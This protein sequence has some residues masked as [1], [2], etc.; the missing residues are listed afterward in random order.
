MWSKLT[1]Y[2]PFQFAVVLSELSVITITITSSER[3]EQTVRTMDLTIFD[4]I[5]TALQG[6]TVIAIPRVSR[7][8]SME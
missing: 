3:S 7:E 8:V 5:T 1:K 6:E 2:K 4:D